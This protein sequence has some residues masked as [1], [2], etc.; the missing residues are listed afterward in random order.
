MRKWIEE[1]QQYLK[2][3]IDGIPSDHH[4]YCL[5]P[6]FPFIKTGS[7]VDL[8]DYFHSKELMYD[9]QKR[10]IDALDG[11]FAFFPDSGTVAECSGLQCEVR[12][13][14]DGFPH[15]KK[16]GITEFDDIIKLKPG[17]P[18]GD[19]FMRRNLEVLE[20]IKPR[21][22][23]E[24]DVV[25]AISNGPFT[26][27]AQFYGI[28]DFCEAI[29]LDPDAVRALLD[30][31]TETCISFLREQEKILGHIDRIII[32]DDIPGFINTS[33]FR[34]FVASDYKRI[35]DA[36]PNTEFW[37]HNDADSIH[38][39]ECIAECGFSVWHMGY[40]NSVTEAAE[41][42]KGKL[43]ICGNLKPID[44]AKINP[45]EAYAACVDELKSFGGNTKLII[46]TGG[47][48]GMGTPIENIL[49]MMRAANEFVI[50]SHC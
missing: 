7:E 1:N 14:D 50:D 13:N 32:G 44:F 29:L 43:S 36:F 23:S 34:E 11:A 26:C 33:H 24:Y 16:N 22:G 5:W 3:S 21:V 8:Y 2:K 12:F 10:V 20:Y 18:W 30:L 49:A 15:V 9:C 19:N 38:L 39:A 37:L 47:F 17:D 28:G 25:P 40:F 41:R 27:A 48:I 4:A 6:S 45:T 31:T 46:S 42:T 35:F